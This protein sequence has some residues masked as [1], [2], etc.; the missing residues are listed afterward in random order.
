M[1]I[2]IIGAGMAGLATA[3][4]LGDAH[5]VVLFDKSRGVGGRMSTRYA[6]EYEFDH[7]AQYF[8]ITDPAFREAVATAGQDASAVLWDS[9]GFYMKAGRAGPDTGRPRWVGA[10]RMNSLP[11][12]LAAG[13]DIRLG[14]RIAS[15]QGSAGALQ[16]QFEDGATEGPFDRVICT[17][18]AP[19]AAALLPDGSPLQ[20]DLARVRMHA[21]FALMVGWPEP[22]DPDWDTL[23]APD[24]PVS[25]IARNQAKPGRNADISSLVVHAA[26]DWSDAHVESD[27]DH[28]RALM[29]DTASTLC[30][31][32]LDG[33]PHIDLHRW[34]YA[35]AEGGVGRDCLSDDASGILL[36]GDWCLGGRVEG[37][38]L[39]GRAAARR[40]LQG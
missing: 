23:R 20:A 38:F 7:G 40:V 18:P 27:R 26:P 9:R 13:L 22:F 11:K 17:A 2:A 28:V 30:G 37:A 36:A 34:L 16:L 14:R 35:Y 4:R 12:A 29:L 21:C 5:E 6:G 32:A 3:R 31:R 39:S 15:V 8:T 10:P 19:Q 24:L 1:K 25:W 33:A